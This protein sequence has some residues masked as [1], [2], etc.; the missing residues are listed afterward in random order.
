M[1]L[2]EH[3]SVAATATIE[4][5]FWVPKRN[6]AFVN[7]RT[8]E[9]LS[10]AVN[11]FHDSNF[12]GARLVCRIRRTGSPTPMA[13][14]TAVR[15]GGDNSRPLSLAVEGCLK[16]ARNERIS[17][18]TFQIPRASEADL[19]VPLVNNAKKRFFIMKS[20]ATEDLESSVHDEH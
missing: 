13:S 18:S 2:K 8:S 6:P 4:S 7:Y 5:I 17:S 9:A 14:T 19:K 3:F 12:D 20:L 11:R 10:D 15:A 1:K 16:T